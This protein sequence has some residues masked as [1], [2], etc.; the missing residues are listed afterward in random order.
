LIHC[1]QKH[2]IHTSGSGKRT[3]MFAH[4]Y[5]CDQNMW[6][7]VAPHFNSENQVILFDHVGSGQSDHN[8]YDFET[9]NTLHAYADDVLEICRELA[10]QDI[11]FVGHS[12]SAMVGILAANKNPN[13]F[14]KLILVAPSPCFI[15]EGDYVGGFTKEDILELI[16]TLES[17][18][19][20]WSSFITPVIIGDAEKAEFADELNQSFCAMNP[21][22]A[23]HFA[24]VTF[25]SD[26]RQDLKESTTEALIL[27]CTPDTLAPVAVGEFLKKELL[28]STLQVIHTPGH[29]PHLTAPDLVIE[30]IQNYM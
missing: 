5:G 20:G 29:C 3:L 26:H 23:K 22:I 8:A 13:L 2:N 25:L 15:N 6:R 1:I 30:A 9:Y 7:F 16:T 24:K 4:G 10:L 14:S 21:A 11:I 28:N 12:V 27:Q 17:N 19:L 18:Y